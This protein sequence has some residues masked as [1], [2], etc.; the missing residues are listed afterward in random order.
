VP[1]TKKNF[2]TTKNL[3]ANKNSIMK[4]NLVASLATLFLLSIASPASFSSTV[5]SQV[6]FLSAGTWANTPL[7]QPQSGSFRITFDATPS[8]INVDAVHRLSSGPAAAYATIFVA[9]RFNTTGHIDAR[10]GSAYTAASAIPYAART[11]YHFILDVNIATHT[12]TA[13]VMIGSLQTTIGTGLAF[14]NQLAP[15]PSLS[16]VAAMTTMGTST[17]CNIT[18]SNSSMAPTI[19]TQPVSQSV[20]AGQMATFSVANTG[21]APLTF[22]G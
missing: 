8:A 7:P 6:C 11:T 21:S 16:Y 19:V 13:Y 9:V 5:N 10:N 18:L 17:I 15:T 1:V 14:R 20:T 2:A 22:Y 12:Y 3:A 4:K